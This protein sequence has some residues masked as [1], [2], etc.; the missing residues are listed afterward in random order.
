ME[1]F[2]LQ[3]NHEDSGE[4]INE[5]FTHC[6]LRHAHKIWHAVV[7][8]KESGSFGS[9][10]VRHGVDVEIEEQ[11][12]YTSISS[13]TPFPKFKSL[14][15]IESEK[16]APLSYQLLGRDITAQSYALRRK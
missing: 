3:V 5:F 1:H 2:T 12:V 7:Q 16:P 13:L 6:L 10:C 15:R 4:T 14:W 8:R 9:T 11:D